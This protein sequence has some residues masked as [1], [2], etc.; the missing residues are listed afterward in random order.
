MQEGGTFLQVTVGPLRSIP[1]LFNQDNWQSVS[2]RAVPLRNPKEVGLDEG[3][4]LQD[5]ILGCVL[6][7]DI[8]FD[9]AVLVVGN[10]PVD[11]NPCTVLGR[12]NLDGIIQVFVTGSNPQTGLPWGCSA[13]RERARQR[14]VLSL[15]HSK[16]WAVHIDTRPSDVLRLTN[17]LATEVEVNL[18]GASEGSHY[19]QTVGPHPR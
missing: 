13:N 17:E 12:V 6:N 18:N 1:G 16:V 4:A 9:R 11:G 8:Q 5:C 2:V 3:P 19:H 15:R 10:V 14:H 7:P